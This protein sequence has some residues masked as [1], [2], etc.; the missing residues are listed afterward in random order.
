M[1][2]Q[3]PLL[4][5]AAALGH[6]G[7][8]GGLGG[9]FCGEGSQQGPALHHTPHPGPVLSQGRLQGEG[10]MGPSPW[11]KGGQGGEGSMGRVQGVEPPHLSP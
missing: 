5:L 1:P 4:V 10:V 9:G 7:G 11:R 6:T 8:A 2:L 3:P